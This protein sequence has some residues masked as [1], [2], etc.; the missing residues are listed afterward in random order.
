MVY[1]PHRVWTYWIGELV[2]KLR[3]DPIP[4]LH[5]IGNKHIEDRTVLLDSQHDLH[6]HEHRVP[7]QRN[8]SLREE[9][10]Q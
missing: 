1:R 2:D 7:P 10:S 9:E 8:L 5:R 3:R 4:Y 6:G